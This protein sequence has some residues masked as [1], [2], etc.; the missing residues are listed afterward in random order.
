M[1]APK[2][3]QTNAG[4]C[5]EEVEGDPGRD[6]D[7]HGSETAGEY[8]GFDFSYKGIYGAWTPRYKP[9][10]DIEFDYAYLLHRLA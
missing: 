1:N 8:G 2:N 9:T 10:M 3:S 4:S 7:L 5:A 6:F